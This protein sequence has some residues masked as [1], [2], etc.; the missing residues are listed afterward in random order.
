MLHRS[1]SAWYAEHGLTDEALQHA[2]AS[3]DAPDA[4]RLV[5]AQVLGAFEHK[6]MVQLERWLR[7]L[8]EE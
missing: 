7:L 8:P 6:Q 2:L 3:G 4:A 1:A 5:E